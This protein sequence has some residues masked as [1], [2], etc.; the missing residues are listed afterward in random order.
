MNRTA[1]IITGNFDCDVRGVELIKQLRLMKLKESRDYFMSVLLLSAL[2]AMPCLCDV[3]TP[4]ASINTR[5]NRSNTDNLLYTP[6]VNCDQFK[7][8]FV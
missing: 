8:S 4:A 7:Q 6:Y 2:T 5:A 1:R 3:L